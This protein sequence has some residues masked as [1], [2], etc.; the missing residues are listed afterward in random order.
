MIEATINS[1]RR[2]G[3]VSRRG[4]IDRERGGLVRRN[5]LGFSFVAFRRTRLVPFCGVF[6]NRGVEFAVAA[7]GCLAIALEFALPTVHA[8]SG[9]FGSVG[10]DLG[11]RCRR[12]PRRHG[13]SVWEQVLM[14][15]CLRAYLRITI[16]STGPQGLTLYK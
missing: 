7:R 12:V 13:E 15:G 16:T 2:L 9:S 3:R 1:T 8:R 10:F 5:R 4:T 11:R 14:R 6:A